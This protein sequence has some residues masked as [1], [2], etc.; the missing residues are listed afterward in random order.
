MAPGDIRST[1]ESVW[2]TTPELELLRCIALALAGILERLDRMPE[3]SGDPSLASP[4]MSWGRAAP[5]T[6]AC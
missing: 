5:A 4:M 1:V 2:T 3:G 6:Q